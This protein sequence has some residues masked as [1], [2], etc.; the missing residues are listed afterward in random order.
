MP[1]LEYGR[2]RGEVVLTGVEVFLAVFVL[3]NRIDS[4]AAMDFAAVKSLRAASYQPSRA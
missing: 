1:H 2:L 3:V 4:P